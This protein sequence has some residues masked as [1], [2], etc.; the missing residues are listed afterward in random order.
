MCMESVFLP[1]S[2]GD[3]AGT[4]YGTREGHHTLITSHGLLSHQ[5]TSKYRLLAQIFNGAGISVFTFDF[6]G[7]GKS[8][9]NLWE[10]TVSGRI[11][12]LEVVLEYVSSF[13]EGGSIS[14]LGSSMG[15]FVSL[16][17][18]FKWGDAITATVIWA[19]PWDLSYF[20]TQ[21]EHFFPQ[22][23]PLFYQELA[24]GEFSAAPLGVKRVLILHGQQD[25]VVPVS[26]AQENFKRCQ[27]PKELQLFPEGDHTFG[28]AADR[29]RAARMSLKWVQSCS[30]SF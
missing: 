3:L 15:G 23:G 12:D 1:S 5:G 7:C 9:G 19:S 24:E 14:L 25:T 29:D 13:P 22:L 6:A 26:Q 16:Q 27:E 28:K 20:L 10:S 11:Q 2:R 8:G 18:A 17:A 30:Q 21:K 4:W